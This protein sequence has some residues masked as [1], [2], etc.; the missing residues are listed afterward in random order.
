MLHRYLSAQVLED[1]Q[2]KMVFIGGPRQ[3]GKTTLSTTL[4]PKTETT[5]LNWDISEHRTAILDGK[6]G[7]SP[8]LVLDEIHKYR[9]WRGYLKGLYDAMQVS[10]GAQRQIIVTGSA[11]LDVYRYGGDSLQGRYH[12]LRLLPLSVA[13]VKDETAF[14]SLLFYGGFPEPFLAH[15]ATHS[16]RFSREYR[17]RLVRED[18][19]DLEAI[20]D[21]ATMELMLGRLPKLVGSPLSINSL[22]EDL[23]IAHR[24]AEKWLDVFDRIYATFRLTPLAGKKLR[25]VKKEKKLYLFDWTNI[26]DNGAR[27]ENLVA[28]HLLK[29]VFFKQDTLGEEVDLCYFRDS[30]GREVDFVITE[31]GHPIILVECK[32]SEQNISQSL[33][34]LH[35]K[36]PR[37]AAWQIYAS[38]TGDYQSKERIRV[39]HAT[40]LLKDLT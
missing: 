14:K 23:Q 13:E 34:F 4:R 19:R 1:A 12:Y 2:R 35:T 18:I 15:S 9:R 10:P 25:S 40:K 38:G 32:Y 3:V 24:T 29:H 22:R 21:L 37:A 30:D 26:D 31:N 17:A 39:A 28:V 36:Y 16:K 5:Y 6:L 11:R 8:L 27:F 7:V 20:Q 33:R